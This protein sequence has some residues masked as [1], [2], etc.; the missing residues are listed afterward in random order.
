MTSQASATM[1]LSSF[2]ESEW[3]SCKKIVSKL[4]EAYELAFKNKT[5]IH[6]DFSRVHGES[7][8]VALSEE[9]LRARPERIIFIDH[10]PHPANLLSL[11]LPRLEETTEIWILLYG[12][13][14]LPNPVEW[15]KLEPLLKHFKLGFISASH[16]QQQFFNQFL[17]DSSA[18]FVCPFPLESSSY[19]FQDR[20]RSETRLALGIADEYVWLYTGRLSQQKN[21]LMLI[22]S[23]A[24][25]KKQSGSRDRLI[26]AGSFDNNG[27]PY[28]GLN[29]QDHE[30]FHLCQDE[31][32]RHPPEIAASITWT[33]LLD[34]Q[35]LKCIYNA[36]DVFVSLSTHNDED[37][38][39]SCAEAL[40]S[41]LPCV[42]TDWGGYASFKRY[43][44]DS[45]HLIPVIF[46][47]YK[48]RYDERQLF[49]GIQ[50]FKAQMSDRTIISGK[51]ADCFSTDAIAKKIE[52]IFA[53][54][55]SRF[56]GFDAPFR[57]LVVKWKAGGAFGDAKSGFNTFYEELYAPYHR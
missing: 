24:R 51:A 47:R 55:I 25:Y 35:G 53:V 17:N 7:D 39:M 50:L 38:G 6:K 26:F 12:D 1:V 32:K 37:Y 9:I 16:R 33:G 54:K 41:G 22:R 44:P 14:V 40:V 29:Y 48:L 8:L 19:S 57:N 45:V 3:N 56:S 20:Q 49:E 5:V 23:F 2:A 21:I 27:I 13:S 42:L 36:C 28:L 34:E 30:Y 43:M 18:S 4:K 31:L 46:D 52:E 10:Q 11:L 15:L